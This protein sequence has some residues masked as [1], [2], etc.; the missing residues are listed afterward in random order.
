[1][2]EQE[3]SDYT[4]QTNPFAIA[5][6]VR[7]SITAATTLTEEDVDRMTMEKQIE[8]Y[9]HAVNKIEDVYM[10]G[11][12]ENETAIVDFTITHPKAVK[13]SDEQWNETAE[14][15]LSGEITDLSVD[16]VGISLSVY[17][18][19]EGVEIDGLAQFEYEEK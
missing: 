1:M 5:E 14:R 19:E 15:I 3:N 11:A 12:S 16:S 8:V 2:T 9:K 13:Q 7:N 18:E 10:D 4:V 6:L 17:T